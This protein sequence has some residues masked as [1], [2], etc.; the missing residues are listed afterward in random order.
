MIHVSLLLGSYL[1]QSCGPP[2]KS[3]RERAWVGTR[4][5]PIL[6]TMLNFQWY[7]CFALATTRFGT[8]G[9]IK[10]YPLKKSSGQGT[11]ELRAAVDW[12]LTSRFLVL[13]VVGQVR[14]K[15]VDWD[16]TGL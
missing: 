5:F 1:Q 9:T 13:D 8:W 2:C 16:E 3:D 12:L 14:F 11:Q 4:G 6:T 10:P 15:E 7:T